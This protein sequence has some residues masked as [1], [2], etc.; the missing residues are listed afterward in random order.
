M[1]DKATGET[2]TIV[3][4][5]CEAVMLARCPLRFTH[6]SVTPEWSSK[7]PSLQEDTSYPNNDED[8]GVVKGW[9]K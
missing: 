9:G 5:N 3:S 7:S 1:P 8:N 6:S 2:R 4:F